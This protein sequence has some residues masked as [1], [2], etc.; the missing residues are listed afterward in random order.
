MKLCTSK[1]TKTFCKKSKSFLKKIMVFKKKKRNFFQKITSFF[2]NTL[3]FFYPLS[4]LGKPL[5]RLMHKGHFR[6]LSEEQGELLRVKALLYGL[7]GEP[8]TKSGLCI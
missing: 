1:K 2:K 7:A 3:I 6:K 4:G 8:I 5:E